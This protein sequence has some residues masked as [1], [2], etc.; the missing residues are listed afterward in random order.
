MSS[1]PE[2]RPR[3]NFGDI[4]KIADAP[5]PPG[6]DRDEGSGVVHLAALEA[7]ERAATPLPSLLPITAPAAAASK[8]AVGWGPM[9]AGTAAFAALIVGALVGSLG[10]TEI[11]GL[12]AGSPHPG[13]PPPIGAGEPD[14]EGPSRESDVAAL[15]L[16]LAASPSEPPE[17]PAEAPAAKV[18]EA[19]PGST[20]ARQ[21]VAALH[22]AAQKTP[23][24][25]PPPEMSTDVTREGSSIPATD[26]TA[27]MEQAVGNDKHAGEAAANDSPAPT[28][29]DGIAPVYPSLGAINS[30]LARPL[31]AAQACVEGD[32]PISH[33]RVKFDATGV[34]GSITVTGWA[35]GKPAEACLRAALTKARVAPFLQASYVVPVTIRSN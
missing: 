11:R 3:R 4:A 30:A 35:A 20:S 32:V 5:P 1:L 31:M 12:I 14:E 26:L 18:I 15:K 8:R 29:P 6:T 13:A 34:V 2:T 21:A 27:R 23:T 17:K 24:K 10:P 22:A 33:A 28:N 19:A 16:P 25:V 9:L 7:A